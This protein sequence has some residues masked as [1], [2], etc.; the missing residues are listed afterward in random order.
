MHEEDNEELRSRRR[1]HG[2]T[3]VVTGSVAVVLIVAAVLYSF[4]YF[5]HTRHVMKSG[6]VYVGDVNDDAA[7]G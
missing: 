2:W 1:A 3:I 5:R 7:T 6:T 4:T